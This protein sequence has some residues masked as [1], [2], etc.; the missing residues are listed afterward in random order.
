[1][2]SVSRGRGEIPHVLDQISLKRVLVTIKR[3]TR[4]FSVTTRACHLPITILLSKGTQTCGILLHCV[5][6]TA[7]FNYVSPYD[8]NW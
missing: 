1:M 2:T 6:D 5:S 3:R 8:V 4:S 7:W